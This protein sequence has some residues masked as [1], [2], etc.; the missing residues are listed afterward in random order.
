MQTQAFFQA[1]Q[2]FASMLAPHI[3]GPSISYI[4]KFWEIPTSIFQRH[5]LMHSLIHSSIT[6]DFSTYLNFDSSKIS[7]VFRLWFWDPFSNNFHYDYSTT[8]L[9]EKIGSWSSWN[10]RS[11]AIL[12]LST[13]SAANLDGILTPPFL[14]SVFGRFEGQETPKS[15]PF[16]RKRHQFCLER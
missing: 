2:V 7:M 10:A 1:L 11:Y 14:L 3:S 9:H 4:V 13:I 16:V 15:T 5:P 12:G 6:E 8:L